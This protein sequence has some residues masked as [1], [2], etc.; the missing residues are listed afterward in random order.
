MDMSP[1]EEQ[2]KKASNVAFQLIRQ[3]GY[4]GNHRVKRVYETDPIGESHQQCMRLIA[5]QG[6]IQEHRQLTLEAW[7]P[8]YDECV[9][10][11]P[12]HRGAEEVGELAIG[13][14]IDVKTWCYRYANELAKCDWQDS[15]CINKLNTKLPFPITDGDLQDL[16]DR[17]RAVE[18][19]L[20]RFARFDEAAPPM[21]AVDP[22]Q[23]HTSD[24]TATVPI[25]TQTPLTE[26]DRLI[27]QAMLE[28]GH[29]LDK[30][31]SQSDI[32]KKALG[33]ENTKG[34]FNRLKSRGYTD[35]AKG[36]GTWLTET[37]VSA[38]KNLS[39]E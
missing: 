14:A 33:T 30:P 7:R 12:D 28:N 36:I 19:Y 13:V 2:I 16:T 9:L 3:I 23:T 1:L 32:V 25:A 10:T 34:V 29:T 35:T 22:T 20:R 27:L 18:H 6:K 8:I 4:A 15:E 31:A 17:L 39:D 24:Q 37:G 21:S 38:A 11:F 5:L 26:S